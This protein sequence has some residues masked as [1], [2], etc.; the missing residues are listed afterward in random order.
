MSSKTTL[1]LAAALMAA[2]SLT[3]PATADAKGRGA[4][5]DFSAVDADKNGTLS[6]AELKAHR[7]A[8][9]TKM[10]TNSDGTITEDEIKSMIEARAEEHGRKMGKRAERGVK[11]MIERA[12]ANE[13]GV[14]TTA[15]LTA[16]GDKRVE[17]MFGRLDADEN[18]EISEDEL[19][20]AR[21][22]RKNKK[23]DN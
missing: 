12:D 4:P 21:K 3:L 6:L 14:L 9:T 20:S 18:G 13:D 10:D 2:L 22:H 11:R 19:R 5:I 1:G 8:R 7:A 15:E 23:A 16:A 17:R